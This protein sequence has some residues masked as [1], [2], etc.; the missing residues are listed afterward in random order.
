MNANQSL[1]L[2]RRLQLVEKPGLKRNSV[3]NAGGA[4]GESGEAPPV[5]GAVSRFRDSG[6]ISGADRRRESLC[7]NGEEA[8][9][10]LDE[11]PR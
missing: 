2:S 1:R 6:T 9:L 7:R 8:R 4:R 5:A 3:C 10:E 11:M